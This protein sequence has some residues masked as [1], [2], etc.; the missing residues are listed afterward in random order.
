MREIRQAFS[1]TARQSRPFQLLV[2]RHDSLI[3]QVVFKEFRF[4]QVRG[5]FQRMNLFQH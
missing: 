4:G 2:K 5:L 3:A 1:L